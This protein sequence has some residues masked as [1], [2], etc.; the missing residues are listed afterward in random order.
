MFVE[1]DLV[2]FLATLMS[3]LFIS[4]EYGIIIG[5]GTHL[6]IVLYRTARPL[7][8][9]QE[10]T[11][12]Y[13]EVLLITLPNIYFPGADYLRNVILKC[14]KAP[15]VILDGKFVHYFDVTVVK[16]NLITK[17]QL[18]YGSFQA[19]A[20]VVQDLEL[21]NQKIVFINFQHSI[22]DL[23][24]GVD[25]KLKTCFRSGG[26]EDVIQGNEVLIKNQ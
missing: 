24:I 13:E 12:N 11:L 21:R 14:E 2:P 1:I 3:S 6:S 4:L 8:R 20:L 18:S 22:Q 15:L 5:I 7:I 19:I 16:V 17:L 10:I 25:K 26:V 9:L 23:C